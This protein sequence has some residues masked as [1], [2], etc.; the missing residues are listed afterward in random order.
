[1]L[2]RLI[3][4]VSTLSGYERDWLKGDISAGITVGIMLIPQGMAYAMIAGLP[5]IYGL[6]A[7]FIPLIAYGLLGG[8]RQ[9]GVGPVAMDSLLVAAAIGP[10]ADDPTTYISLALLLAFMVG[11]IQF[12]LGLAKA[13]Y[14]V[15]FLSSPVLAGFTSAA[16]LIIGFNQLRHLLG[17]EVGRSTYV[18]QIVGDAIANISDVHL[19]TLFIG[20]AAIV[21]LVAMRR[22]KP[23][24]PA[25]LVVVVASTTTVW[26]MDLASAGVAIVGQVPSG[27]PAFQ[28]PDLN[29]ASIRSLIPAAVTIALVAFMEAIA[30]S[31]VYARKH[32]YKVDPNQELKSLGIANMTGALFQAYPT[33]GGFS[34]TALNDQAGAKTTVSLL[35]SAAVIGLTLIALTDLFHFLP[36]AVLAA[37]VMVAVYKLV[38]VHEAVYLWRVDRRDFWLMLV[39]FLSTSL[40]GITEGIVIGVVLSVAL[41]IQQSSK[42]Y[43]V[44]LGQLPG[45]R[46]YRS[47]ERNPKVTVRPGIVVFRV[48]ASLFFANVEHWTTKLAAIIE[49]DHSTGAIVFDFYPVNRIDS[50]AVQA[51]R[52]VTEQL[53]DAKIRFAVTGTKGPVRETLAKAGLDELIGPDNFFM[54]IHDAVEAIGGDS[55]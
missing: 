2:R 55:G 36:N 53:R 20:I 30:V 37:V 12:V 41:V 43:T 26:A 49:S 46:S 50:T 7:S 9:L 27:L 22:L 44:V 35:I 3:P 16:A 14:L 32:K 1:M 6:Y 48:D 42:P 25:T 31:K 47:V 45:R 8:S 21:A 39:T 54:E 10:L 5:P 40:F 23:G 38:E 24:F 17:I 11:L 29:V 34:R 51:L 28:L 4:L 52:E 18:Y 15:N 19:T 13:G 33:T